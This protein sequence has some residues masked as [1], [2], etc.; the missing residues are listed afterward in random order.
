MAYYKFPLNALNGNKI[1]L[2][3]FGN[4]LRDFTHI[5]DIVGGIQK[6]IEKAKKD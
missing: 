4:D 5:S 6:L 2:N 1:L 3:N